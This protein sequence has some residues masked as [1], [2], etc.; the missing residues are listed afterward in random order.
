M[1]SIIDLRIFLFSLTSNL[2]V[3]PTSHQHLPNFFLFFPEH[4]KAGLK[5]PYKE[6]YFYQGLSSF[7]SVQHVF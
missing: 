7:S 1:V 4:Y 5:Y 3:Y 6:F 2:N